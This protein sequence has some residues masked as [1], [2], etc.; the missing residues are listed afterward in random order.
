MTSRLAASGESARSECSESGGM[1]ITLKTS[2]FL[3][4]RASKLLPVL[5]ARTSRW[6]IHLLVDALE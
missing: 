4:A 3:F 6:P 1:A 2:E 5:S